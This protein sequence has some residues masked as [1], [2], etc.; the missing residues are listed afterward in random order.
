MAAEYDY[1]VPIV[2]AA[3]TGVAAHTISG[4]TLHSLFRLPV[5]SVARF[6]LP[7]PQTLQAL[8]ANMRGVRY[9]IIDENYLCFLVFQQ[10]NGPDL[11]R[12]FH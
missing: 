6:E 11:R 2:R 7:N 1:P 4:R 3:P 8:Q 5:K 9:L 12:S 10:F